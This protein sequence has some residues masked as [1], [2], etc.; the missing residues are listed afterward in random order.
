M[1]IRVAPAKPKWLVPTG[2]IMLSLIPMAAGGHRVAELTGGTE[3][4]PDNARFF[5]MPV[6]VLVHIL[7]ASLFCVLGAFQFVPGLRRRWHRPAGRL[8][9]LSGLAAALSGIW[10]TLFLTRPFG[11]LLS[12]LRLLFGTAMVL[13]IVLGFV[14]IRRRDVLKHRAWMIRGYAI[15][16]GAGTQA[17]TQA[18]LIMLMGTPDKLG[19]ALAIGAGWV[20]NLV[21]AQHIISRIRENR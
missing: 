18:L 12:V 4:T 13:S 3:I 5:A 6:P 2:L 19:T 11:D 21:V 9:I 16:Q 8:I 1:T 14:A 17:L 10:M 15:G 7:S 20:I